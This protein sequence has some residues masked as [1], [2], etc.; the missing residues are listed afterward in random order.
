MSQPNPLDFLNDE[1]ARAVLTTHG[2]LMVIAGPG[3]GKTRVI[4][5]RMARLITQLKVPPSSV[6]AVTFTNKAAAELVARLERSVP[7]AA[8]RAA[9]VSTFH[10]FCG[11]LN[12]RYGPSIG[13]NSEY[14]IY[15]HDDQLTVVR[16]AMEAAGFPPTQSSIR[17]NDVLSSI[18]KAK[19]L[20]LGPADYEDWLRDNDPHAEP[21]NQAAAAAY[22]LYQRELSMSN[23]VDFDDII[24]RSVRILNES[25]RVADAVHRQYRYIMV[26]E[27]QDTNHAQHELTRL[28]TGPHRNICVVGD[29]NQSI[30]GWRNAL[31]RNILDFPQHYPEA[32][33]VRLGRNY[34]SSENIVQAA[35]ALISVNSS[36]IHNPLSAMDREGPLVRVAAT[37][38]DESQALW[39]VQNMQTLV[40]QKRCSWNDCAVMYRTNAQSRAFE[41]LCIQNRVP[42]RIIGGV[43]F[44]QRKEIK[45]LL[46]YLRIIQNPGDSV[47]L[48]RIINT[49]PRSIGAVTIQKILNF[50]D[51]HTLTLMQGTRAAVSKTGSADRPELSDRPTAAVG[52]FVSLVDRLA[53]ATT[54]H[55]LTDIVDAIT[56]ET[57]LYDYI[58]GEDNAL[59]RWEN[60]MELRAST[61]RPEYAHAPAQ[62]TLPQFLEHVSL[63]AD[64][65][66]YD[67]TADALTLITL[68]QAKGLEFEAVAI[69]GMIE[70]L[71]P[72]ARTDDVEEERRLC[73]VGLTRAKTHL[74]LSWP[75]TSYQYGRHHPNSPSRFLDEL[76]QSRLS[77]ETYP[78]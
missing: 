50:S 73:Y 9:Q 10:R 57:N 46:A 2:P 60:I 40:R 77:E 53:A 41:E 51:T 52:R 11:Q 70:G 63:F 22:P 4:I 24:M 72:H 58:K 31:I 6:M 56:T 54:D 15:D 14:T 55:T 29:P 59:E 66:D 19:S 44:Y 64:V 68:H 76:P 47:S 67:P 69:P 42:Y 32:E 13:L 36:R 30:Y 61:A 62:E 18:S 34:R 12:R 75:E 17:P 35:A 74:M 23:A 20:L 7:P 71:M 38:D 21:A 5:Q 8:A 65:D 45:D 48:Q 43:R 28:I 33:V 37:T 1:Q 3:S 25:P 39:N 27:Y 78:D 26:D 16:R 49:P